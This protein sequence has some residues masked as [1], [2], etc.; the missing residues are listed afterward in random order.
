M[1]R[2]NENNDF[3]WTVLFLNRELAPKCA[4]I[5]HWLH[6]ITAGVLLQGISGRAISD[7][8]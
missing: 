1:G 7:S 4:A 3:R 6:A 8:R 2:L 5:A